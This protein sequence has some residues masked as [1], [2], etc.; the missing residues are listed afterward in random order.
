[1]EVPT[2][3]MMTISQLEE[4]EESGDGR[5]F[6]VQAINMENRS[7]ING[8][9][10]EASTKTFEIGLSIVGSTNNSDPAIQYSMASGSG[11]AKKSSSKHD[12]SNTSS[13]GEEVGY[14]MVHSRSQKK[15]LNKLQKQSKIQIDQDECYL[16]EQ[17]CFDNPKCLS[18]RRFDDP[19]HIRDRPKRIIRKP[20]R[21]KESS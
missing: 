16:L 9:W 20:T 12:V 6:D 17:V 18:A 11:G 2:E 7:E 14:S 8:V 19:S 3:K 21:F 10:G 5:N 15:N 4:I 1:M 13:V